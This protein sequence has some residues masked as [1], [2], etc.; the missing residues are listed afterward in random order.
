MIFL[1]TGVN[2]KTAPVEVRERLAFDHTA[3]P[4]ALADLRSCPGVFEGLN[5]FYLQPRRDRGHGG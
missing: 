2:H 3:L 4:A 5:P 1:I